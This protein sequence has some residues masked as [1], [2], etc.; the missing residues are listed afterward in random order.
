MV[1]AF[2]LLFLGPAS[3]DQ[4][5]KIV[6]I[7]SRRTLTESQQQN[8]GRTALSSGSRGGNVRP[9]QQT[10]LLKLHVFFLY[11]TSGQGEQIY[12]RS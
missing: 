2:S 1:A 5:V 4:L 11:F 9:V 12:L 8:T 6:L 7:K 10:H 3:K